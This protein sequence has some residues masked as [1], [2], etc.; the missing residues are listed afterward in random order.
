[1]IRKNQIQKKEKENQIMLIPIACLLSIIPL[2]VRLVYVNP[3][4]NTMNGLFNKMN[5]DDYYSQGKSVGIVLITI[6]MIM[7][8]Y[9]LA[10][11]DKFKLDQ[12]IKVYL[13]STGILWFMTIIS[14]LLSSYKEISIWGM[15]DRAEGLVV[16]SCYF[17]MM[18]Y[19]LYVVRDRKG[20]RWIIGSLIFLITVTTILGIFQYIGYDLLLNTDIGNKLVIPEKYRDVAQKLTSSVESHKIVTTFYHYDY[21]G[22]F[23]AMMVPLFTVLVLTTKEIT[24]KI[25]LGV[26]TL[27]SLFILFGSTSRAGLVGCILALTVG[28][29]VFGKKIVGEWKKLLA[30]GGL[31]VVILI[32][33]NFLTNGKIYS[34]IPTLVADIKSL[35]SSSGEV[36]DYRDY[37]PVREIIEKE[38]KVVFVLQ[39]DKL[40]LSYEDNQ[41][42]ITD[43]NDR[44]VDYTVQTSEYRTQDGQV[45]QS[46]N[47]TTQDQRYQYIRIYRQYINVLNNNQPID[48][49][50]VEVDNS[51]Y[52]YFKIED[53][54]LQAIN[55]FSGE[56]IE[57]KEADS[58]GF[59]GKEKIGSA[60]GYIWSRALAIL[61]SRNLL[62][63]NGPDTFAIY[64]PQNDILAKWWVYDMTNIIVDKPHN[65]YLQIAINQGGIA[66]IAFI[67][68]VGTYIIQ[69]LRLYALKK[70]YNKEYQGIGIGI[71]LAIIGYLGAGFFNDSI[72]S[73]API[74]WILLGTGMAV[75]YIS[76]K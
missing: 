2:I 69:S 28:L 27:A 22:S 38:G 52:F 60:R 74:F 72:I 13:V 76:K 56:E 34:R 40:K 75:N 8:F 48:A 14:T 16:W 31:I 61:F 30:A 63:G 4:D 54:G 73:V 70:S 67:V 29:I 23:G 3:K 7:L 12:Y 24:K 44:L 65:L 36:I 53:T 6:I 58:I 68:L 18:L 1:M 47:Y 57:Y 33:F 17:I 59:K 39:Q 64:F 66:L 55:S 10:Q 20:Y 37:I 25:G 45:S 41:L 15:Y 35:F 71:M 46:K 51:G 11:R 9:F 62:I 32:S 49:I 50:L 21:V 19:T 26:A 43:E 5:L 42:M